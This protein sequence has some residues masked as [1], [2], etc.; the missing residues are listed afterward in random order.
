MTRP[1]MVTY[2]HVCAAPKGS[3][4]EALDIVATS[5]LPF[6]PHPGMMI[7]P[8]IG[9]DSLKVDEV[10]WEVGKPFELRVF[11]EEPED[12]LQP[13]SYWKRQQWREAP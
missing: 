7:S 1:F 9:G 6:V 5:E 3:E 4:F 2:H 8:T 10:F 11:F 12:D 13:L